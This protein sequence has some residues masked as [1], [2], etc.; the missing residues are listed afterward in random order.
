M[1]LSFLTAIYGIFLPDPADNTMRFAFSCAGHPPPLLYRA[2][3]GTV[4]FIAARGPII[5]MLP[6]INCE[7]ITIT[8][9]KGDRIYLYTDGLPETQNGNKEL[10]ELDR[11]PDLIRAATRPSLSETLDA[12]TDATNAFRGGVRFTDDIVL[13]GFE[14][15]GR[16]SCRDRVY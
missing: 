14:K 7:K 3:T 12:I 5:G 4:D 16:A 8:P 13:I 15:I 6:S 11:L 1:P 2:D 10:I 9:K